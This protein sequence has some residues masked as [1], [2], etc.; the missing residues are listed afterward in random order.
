MEIQNK[1]NKQKKPQIA[2][3]TLKKKKTGTGGINL[4]DFTL[5]YKTTV[6]KTVWYWHKD[7]NI[8]QWDKIESPEV[9]PCTYGHLKIYKNIQWRQKYT[10]E[11][12]Q[13]L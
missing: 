10:M 11:K 5:Y 9:N 8:S 1:T 2:K 3:V 4:S 7:R 13:S 6:I 12:R